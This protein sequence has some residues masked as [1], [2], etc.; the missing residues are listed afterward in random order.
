MKILL[1][2]EKKNHMI[3][4]DFHHVISLF[5]RERE[6]SRV[7]HDINIHLDCSLQN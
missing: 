1:N 4:V 5:W 6:G 2:D 3:I 7:V